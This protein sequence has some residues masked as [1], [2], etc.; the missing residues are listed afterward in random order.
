M[1]DEQKDQLMKCIGNMLL[2]LV[3]PC[4]LSEGQLKLQLHNNPRF[5][6][7]CYA[8]FHLVSDNPMTLEKVLNDMKI[9]SELKLL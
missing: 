3:S 9:M 8:I 6:N 5:V 7:S 2:P 4:D 1:N